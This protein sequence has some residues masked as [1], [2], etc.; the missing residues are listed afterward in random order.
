M[1]KKQKTKVEVK[2]PQIKKEVVVETTPV[3]EK[4]KKI[5]PKSNNLEDNWEIKDRTYLLTKGRKPL[6]YL[7]RGSNIF[8]VDEKKGYEREL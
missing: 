8:W 3:I 6:T 2:E 7:I 1:A 5:Q 4:P